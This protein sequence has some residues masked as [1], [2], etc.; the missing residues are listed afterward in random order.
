MK[1]A[2]I[3]LEDITSYLGIGSLHLLGLALMANKSFDFFRFFEAFSKTSGWAILF[4]IPLI[5][6][7]YLTGLISVLLADVMF[8]FIDRRNF[9]TAKVLPMLYLGN[10]E[11]LWSAFVESEKHRR[12]LKGCSLGFL[13]LAGGI[14]ESHLFFA[15]S[16]PVY[17]VA[18]IAALC[19]LAANLIRRDFEHLTFLLLNHVVS[20][21][22]QGKGATEPKGA[23]TPKPGTPNIVAAN[24]VGQAD[25]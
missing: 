8:S 4:A 23:E 9:A 20:L 11:R 21:D 18:V 19:P 14:E 3:T 25:G 1:T 5:V 6:T 16:F 13:T 17:I 7:M 12:L 15:V 22:Q 10:S 24:T 2:D